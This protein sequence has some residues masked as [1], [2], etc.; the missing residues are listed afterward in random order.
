MEKLRPEE[1]MENEQKAGGAGRHSHPG[2]E[3]CPL[4]VS[5]AQPAGQWP[6]LSSGCAQEAA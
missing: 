2:P 3:W 6:E 5:I 1:A 4:E